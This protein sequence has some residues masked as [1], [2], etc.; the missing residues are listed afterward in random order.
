MRS[1]IA[2]L[3]AAVYEKDKIAPDGNLDE[4]DRHLLA[5]MHDEYVRSGACLPSDDKREELRVALEEI[6]ALRCEAQ[7]AFTEEEDGIWFQRSDLAGV[8]ENALKSMTQEGSRIWVTYRND[9]VTAVMRHALS[10]EIRRKF[11]LA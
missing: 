3:V 11:A 10:S 8:P 9:H 7:V 6:N 1:D 4:Q 5:H 2:S